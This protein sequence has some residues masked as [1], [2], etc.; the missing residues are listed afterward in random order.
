MA[1]SR[2]GA[3]RVR[4]VI[5]VVAVVASGLCTGPARRAAAQGPPERPLKEILAVGVGEWTARARFVILYGVEQ[6]MVHVRAVPT[7]SNSPTLTWFGWD[8]CR[9]TWVPA[10][11]DVTRNPTAIAISYPVTERPSCADTGER[12]EWVLTR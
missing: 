11:V 4:A 1:M 3:G 12:L 7:T 2:S 9:Q 10:K 6:K 8:G 5:V